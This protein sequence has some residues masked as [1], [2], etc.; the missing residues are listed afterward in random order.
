MRS[1]LK[2]LP[3]LVLLVLLAAP[4]LAIFGPPSETFVGRVNFVQETNF[5][6]ITNDNRVVR[7]MIAQDRKL[8]PEVQLGVLVEVRAVQG[9]DQ[10]WYLD[11]FE[12]IQLQPNG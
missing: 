1:K 2:F 8:P 6:L 11:K 10:L 9:E 12:R 3:A 7:I 5:S 4:A